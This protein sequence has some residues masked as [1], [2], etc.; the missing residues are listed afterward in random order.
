LRDLFVCLWL[1]R[2][3]VAVAAAAAPSPPAVAVSP[4]A[5]AAAAAAVASAAASAPT[6]SFVYPIYVVGQLNFA[7]LYKLVQIYFTL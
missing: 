5:V 7:L 2:F 4:V 3:S 6:S 1:T